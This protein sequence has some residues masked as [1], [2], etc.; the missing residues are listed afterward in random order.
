ML[1]K[2]KNRVDHY[3]FNSCGIPSHIDE[4]IAKQY[5]KKFLPSNPTIVDCGAHN[6]TD[7]MELYEALRGKIYAF[8]AVPELFQK[9]KQKTQDISNITC[10]QMALAD[11]NQP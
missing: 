3:L 7:T 10:F 8:E 2:I 9:L 11:K 1:Q 5:I 6:G 4:K